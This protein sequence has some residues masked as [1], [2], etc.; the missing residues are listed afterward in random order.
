MQFN[1]RG[2]K[3]D[4]EPSPIVLAA[5]IMG[6]AIYYYFSTVREPYGGADSVLFIKPL[7]IMLL[8][9]F[10]FVALSAVRIDSVKSVEGKVQKGVSGGDRGFLDHRRLFFTAS[11]AA[12][13]AG[14]TVFGYLIPSILFVFIVCFYLGVRNIWILIGLPVV[15]SA[16]LSL[17]FNIF[18]HVPIPIWPSW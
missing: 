11:L 15:L 8:L 6:W 1:I 7:T 10:I 4:V 5:L 18:M 14:L 9:C 12:Y 16:L 3:V 2:R 13:A 17:V